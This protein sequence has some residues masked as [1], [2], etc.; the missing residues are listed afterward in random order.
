V[1]LITAWVDMG[2]DPV[3]PGL[4]NPGTTP[5]DV[6]PVTL[7]ALVACAATLAVAVA[8]AYDRTERGRI[9]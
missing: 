4:H 7:V 9:N 5:A 2:T 3:G 1:L 8:I 6:H